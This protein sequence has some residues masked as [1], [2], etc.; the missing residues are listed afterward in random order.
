MTRKIAA[1][2]LA[3][4]IL[5]LTACNN[6]IVETPAPNGSE[7]SKE[8]DVE[9]TPEEVSKNVSEELVI[10]S[11]E[12]EL[13]AVYSYINDGKTHPTVLFIAG[14]GAKDR[15]STSI[16]YKPFED[17]AN[18]LLEKGICSLRV[19]K[20]NFKYAE[21][22]GNG[23]LEEEYLDDCRAAIELLKSKPATG[24]I[25][26]F[27]H[28][29]G[30]QISLILEGEYSEISGIVLFNSTLRH[31]ADLYK[32]QNTESNPDYAG[33]YELLTMFAKG[34]NDFMT[35]GLLY[36]DLTDYY[37]ASYNKYDFAKLA[38]ET[39]KPLLVIN[40]SEDVQ[41]YDADID[42]FEAV[43]AG[44]ENATVI[45]DDEATHF[46][47][48]LDEDSDAEYDVYIMSETIINTIANFINK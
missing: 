10:K 42:S 6:D 13:D 32:D 40:C 18:A 45:V 41:M 4:S 26:L 9:S 33:T 34:T 14:I 47:Y 20:R 29:L 46:G 31:L 38:T 23:G 7:S 17:I 27:G 19:D 44:K 30:G 21:K 48:V 36:Y 15:H 2:L 16:D 8:S 3:L 28:S 25:Y 1:I 12:F 39:E 24:E 5:L 43:L 22:F 37:W 35:Q 11:G